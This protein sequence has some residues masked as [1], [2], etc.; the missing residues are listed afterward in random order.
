MKMTSKSSS[1]QDQNKKHYTGK[2]I[3]EKVYLYAHE[4]LFH[5]I[6]AN[7]KTIGI[8]VGVILLIVIIG[9]SWRAYQKGI[10]E[11][12]LAL[13]G[14]AFQRHQEVQADLASKEQATVSETPSDAPDPYQEV[15]ALYQDIIDQYPGTASAGRAQYLLGSIAYQR[16]NYDEAKTFFSDYLKT[17]SK[18]P[19]AMQAEESIAYVLEQQQDY[20]QAL[21]TFKR[22]ETRVSETRKPAIL[23]AVAR[24]YEALGQTESAIAAYQSVVDSNTSFSLKNT[25]KERLDLLQMAQREPR[26]ITTPLPQEPAETT[27][28][29][30]PA[31]ETSPVPA[32]SPAPDASPVPQAQEPAATSSS[33]ESQPAMSVQPVSEEP[34]AEIQP[35][36][37]LSGETAETPTDPQ[38]QETPSAETT[39]P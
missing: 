13:E 32:E 1:K 7:V 9:F 30:P 12:A 37:D 23:L 24:N 26:I 4:K 8:V 33:S 11:K 6:V 14:K 31:S 17:F 28:V 18:G 16:G 20:Q 38:I 15:I 34:S 29:E 39:T 2:N 22:L 10:T 27:S 19:L 21:D 36:E 25:A 5:W 35:Q 3:E